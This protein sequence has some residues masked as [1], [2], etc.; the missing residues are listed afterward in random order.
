MK[1]QYKQPALEIL[2]ILMEDSILSDQIQPGIVDGDD[3]Y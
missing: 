1:R 3:E 2:Y